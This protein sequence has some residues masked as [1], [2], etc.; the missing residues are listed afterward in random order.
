MVRPGR[1]R[2]RVPMMSL[3]FLIC[4]ILPAPRGPRVYSISKTN[5]YQKQKIKFL[6][7]RDRPERKAD[8]AVIFES[9]V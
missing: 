1:L 2:D 8:L 9:T 7:S 3:V 5:E 6:E 4:L